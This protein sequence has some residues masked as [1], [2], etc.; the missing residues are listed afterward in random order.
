MR[1][2]LPGGN[3]IF[4]DNGKNQVESYTN[5]SIL[6]DSEMDKNIDRT[7]QTHNAATRSFLTLKPV[8]TDRN[9]N[10]SSYGLEGTLGLLKALLGIAADVPDNPNK[11][12]DDFLNQKPIKAPTNNNN[13][14]TIMQLFQIRQFHPTSLISKANADYYVNF[15][16]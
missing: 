14:D 6:Q 2:E 11:E 9:E 13:I 8:D 4:D 1:I 12:D 3:E 5:V 15:F 10:A 16:F 7:D